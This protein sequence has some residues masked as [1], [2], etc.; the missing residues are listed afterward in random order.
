MHR[1]Q[2]K[3]ENWQNNEIQRLASSSIFIVAEGKSLWKVGEW[4]EGS[5]MCIERL[6]ENKED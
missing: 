5:Y 3:T 1:E 2:T 4:N 6:K